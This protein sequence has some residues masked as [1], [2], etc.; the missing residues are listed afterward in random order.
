MKHRVDDAAVDL[1]GW[2]E[3][4]K[5]DPVSYRRRQVAHIL[6]HAIATTPALKETLYLKGGILMALAYKSVRSTSDIDFT[7][8]ED[9]D[10]FAGEIRGSL[11]RALR[12]AVADLA[13]PL[14]CKVQ[15]TRKEPKL[16]PTAT[17]PSLEIS[18]ASAMRGTNEE[19]RLQDGQAPQVLWMEVSFKEPVEAVQDLVVGSA[20]TTVKAYARVDLIAEKLRALLQQP[21]RK[22]SRRQD[23]YDLAHLL[24]ADSPDESDRD[25]ILRILC[26]KSKARGL[27]PMHNSMRH[28]E[29]YERAKAEWATMQAELVDPLPDFDDTFRIVLE[30]YETLPWSKV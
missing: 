13:Y 2:V 6:L 17:A 21:I 10:V 5:S 24:D 23:V 20:M 7:T 28:P 14:A 9:P 22:R 8:N 27:D 11:D 15:S 26:I 30:F 25:E 1:A 16:F 29:I 19:R 12:R 4:A 18:I 3:E